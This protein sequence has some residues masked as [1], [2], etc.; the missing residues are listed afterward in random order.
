MFK[1]KKVLIIAL[2]IVALLLI[3]FVPIPKTAQ[4]DDGSALSLTSLTYKVIFWDMYKNSE[5]PYN[6]TEFL[7]LPNNFKSAQTLWDKRKDNLIRDGYGS[8]IMYASITQKDEAGITVKEI[9]TNQ[10]DTSVSICYI[11][12]D[13]FDKLS[14]G[15][16]YTELSLGRTIVIV[17]DGVILESYPA[18]FD[19]IFKITISDSVT[20]VVED[21]S[22][23][24]TETVSDKTESVTTSS[25]NSNSNQEIISSH[26]T[27]SSQQNSSTNQSYVYETSK[28]FWF[29]NIHKYPENYDEQ[30]QLLMPYI[31]VEPQDYNPTKKYPVILYFHGKGDGY[32]DKDDLEYAKKFNQQ[33]AF[34]F[35]DA[36]SDCYEWLDQAVIIMPQL[37]N[38]LWWEF[39]INNDGPLDAAMRIFDKV[40]NEFSCDNSR[41]YVMGPSM[42]GYATIMVAAKHSD[43]FAAAMPLCPALSVGNDLA[44]QLK[45]IPMF[46]LHGKNDTTVLPS[47]SMSS[48][49]AIK[50]A[51]GRDV[52]IKLYDGADH[53]LW[54]YAYK[55]D[56]IW[57]WLFSQKKQ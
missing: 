28:S 25:A 2:S 19:N 43:I 5:K 56:E 27:T 21:K 6:K 17:Y 3:L 24:S 54:R 48:C 38:G 7:L 45:N 44:Y 33:Q 11:S 49:G 15:I 20:T 37:Q 16:T 51:G 31:V 9:L 22:V 26:E 10:N 29:Q 4:F 53:N 39:G 12:K 50:I 55:D 47:Y 14:D 57:E 32:P 46:F 13:T 52:Y 1:N 36:Y 42:G 41:Y 34:Q 23:S 40:T 8:V 30:S 35:D 18:M